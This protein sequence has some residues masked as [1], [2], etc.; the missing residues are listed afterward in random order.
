L[1]PLAI[2]PAAALAII[3]RSEG[4]HFAGRNFRGHVAESIWLPPEVRS[5]RARE[6]RPG[7]WSCLHRRRPMNPACTV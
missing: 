7:L 4:V 1:D 6:T 2:E 5:S 3:G